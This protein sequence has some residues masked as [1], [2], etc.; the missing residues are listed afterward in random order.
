M[1]LFKNFFRSAPVKTKTIFIIENNPG[2]AESLE[3]Y[4]NSCIKDVDE[5]RIFPVAELCMLELDCNPAVVIIDCLPDAKYDDSESGMELIKRLKARKPNTNII[6]L[7]PQE[8]ISVAVALI[9]EF[10]CGYVK[11]GEHAFA[12]VEELI[13]EVW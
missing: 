4:L 2:Y 11:K 3:L 9:K 5:I 1:T 8:E 6:L 10:N 12:K 13:K 7:S